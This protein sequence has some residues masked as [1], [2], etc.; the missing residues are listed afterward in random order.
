MDSASWT[1]LASY[2]VLQSLTTFS[3][4][5]YLRDDYGFGIVSQSIQKKMSYIL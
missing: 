1:W 2:L 4:S 5:L 3:G